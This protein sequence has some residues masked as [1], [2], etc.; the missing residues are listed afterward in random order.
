MAFGLSDQVVWRACKYHV[1][2]LFSAFWSHVYHPVGNLDDVGMMFYYHYA[3]PAFYQGMEGRKQLLDVVKM[4]TSGRLVKDK[5]HGVVQCSFHQIG[6]KFH[7]LG[8]TAAERAAALSKF[9][10][11][12][13]DILEWFEF[14][15]NTGFF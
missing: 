6:S 2:T 15:H 9:Q 1:S 10:V 5:H 8:F 7:T 12:Q 4:Q 14:C 3:V 13:T 11:A